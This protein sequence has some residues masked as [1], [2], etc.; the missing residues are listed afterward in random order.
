VLIYIP[1]RFA[2]HACAQRLSSVPFFSF[3]AF[4]GI[5]FSKREG[6]GVWFLLV[7]WVITTKEHHTSSPQ[8]VAHVRGVSGRFQEAGV[9]QVQL[10]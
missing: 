7:L 4:G 2:A 10:S 3:P 1:P 6:C 8:H 9:A 5:L